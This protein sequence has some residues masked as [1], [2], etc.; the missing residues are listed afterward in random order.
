MPGGN[1][2]IE[3]FTPIKPMLAQR[4]HWKQ[5]IS[6][7][8]GPF[9]IEIKYDGERVMVHYRKNEKIMMWSRNGF[10]LDKKY[11]YVKAFGDVIK[12]QFQCE[13]CILDGEMMAWDEDVE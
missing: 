11:G 13:S 3:L 5:V 2:Q 8:N 1:I 4:R 10:D 9:G 7:M 12:Q 6:V